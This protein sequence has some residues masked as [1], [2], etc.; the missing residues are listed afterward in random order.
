MSTCFI[1]ICINKNEWI[2]THNPTV[3]IQILP[4]VFNDLNELFINSNEQFTEYCVKL[5][6][7]TDFNTILFCDVIPRPTKNL[8]NLKF[9]FSEDKN[10]IDNWRF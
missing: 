6:Q 7:G 9:P 8:Y 4:V 2:N 3:S 10:T 5:V 1:Y